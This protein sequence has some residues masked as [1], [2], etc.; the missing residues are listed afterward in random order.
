MPERSNGQV[1]KTL[2]GYKSH[3]GP[4][5]SPTA[6]IIICFLSKAYFYIKNERSMNS[7]EGSCGK[8][9]EVSIK[10]N[11]FNPYSCYPKTG[12]VEN[13]CGGPPFQANGLSSKDVCKYLEEYLRS[14]RCHNCPKQQSL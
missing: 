3:G 11:E 14:I 8:V 4:N 10:S 13:D 7:I 6:G 2:G 9:I 1:S 5:P 12:Y